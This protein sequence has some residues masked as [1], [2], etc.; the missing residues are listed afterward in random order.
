[1]IN[2]FVT[3]YEHRKG[4]Q[5]SSHLL[6]ADARHTQSDLYASGAVLLSFIAVRGGIAWAD[7]VGALVLVVLIGRA[8]W[9]VFRE[10]VPVL[11]DAAMLE[12][13]GV[14]RLAGEVAGVENVHRVRSRGIRSAVELDLHMEVAP[15]MT[16]IEAHGLATRIERDLRLKFPELSDVVIHIEPTLAGA[17]SGKALRTES[18]NKTD[19]NP[20]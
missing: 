15:T 2:F 9:M 13:E 1:V 5:L 7:G 20:E 18:D 8:A 19:E 16:V 11:I 10:N 6:C 3:R 17:R 14:I 12:P 4:D